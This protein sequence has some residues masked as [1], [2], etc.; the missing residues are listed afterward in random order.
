MEAA[1]LKRSNSQKEQ[2][3]LGLTLTGLLMEGTSA[4]DCFIFCDCFQVGDFSGARLRQLRVP[5]SGS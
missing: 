4:S 5:I 3:R 1:R 2:R